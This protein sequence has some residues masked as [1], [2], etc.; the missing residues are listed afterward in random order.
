MLAHIIL[1]IL[2]KLPLIL[3][4]ILLSYMSSK[5]QCVCCREIIQT[6][7]I[8]GNRLP[9]AISAKSLQNTILINA[10]SPRHYHQQQVRSQF[11]ISSH[12]TTIV[13][14]KKYKFMKKSFYKI[15]CPMY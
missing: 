3:D 6:L 14:L 11:A 5:G 2:S 7:K 4:Q 12:L 9:R 13:A 1:V 15:V 8:N 10:K